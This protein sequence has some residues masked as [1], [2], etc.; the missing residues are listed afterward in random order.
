MKKI[1]LRKYKKWIK[2]IIILVIDKILLY[3]NL[4]K[5]KKY[6]LN[7]FNQIILLFAN[8]S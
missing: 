2:K 8:S 5:V 4:N 1:N 7:I 6:S 3:V